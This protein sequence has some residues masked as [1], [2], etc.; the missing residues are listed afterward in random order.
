MLLPRSPSTISRPYGHSENCSA[1]GQGTCQKATTI[2]SQH[3]G[4]EREVVVLHQDNRLVT[5]D[6][7][8]DG[9]GKPPV[10]ALVTYPIAPSKNRCGKRR[11]TERPKALV[12]KA[13][14]VRP[15][16]LR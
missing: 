5:S 11:V 10:D 9:V 3:P 15:L 13:V 2:A 8:G 4:Y 14:V 7:L 12:G 1:A 16:L 6:F